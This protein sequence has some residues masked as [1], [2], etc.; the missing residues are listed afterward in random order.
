MYWRESWVGSWMPPSLQH[1]STC[2]V[3]DTHHKIAS[4]FYKR[5]FAGIIIRSS[6]SLSFKVLGDSLEPDAPP[7]ILLHGLLGKKTHWES[8]GKTIMNTAKRGV[9]VA[10]L[11][12]HGDSPHTSSHTY[13]DLAEDV[14]DL[15]KK[16]NID[17]TTLLGHSMGGRTAMS[18]ALMKPTVVSNLIVVDVSPVSSPGKMDDFF[19]RLWDVMKSVKFEAKTLA[20]AR[21]E[22]LHRLKESGV[23]E[24]FPTLNFLLMNVIERKNGQFGW[25]CNVVVLQK[26]FEYIASFPLELAGKFYQGPTLFIAGGESNYVP[27]SDTKGIREFFPQAEIQFVKKAGHNVHFDAPDTFLSLV[28]TF[29]REYS[30]K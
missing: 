18:L 27:L 8:V 21:Q 24:D 16:L 4:K 28:T 11:R 26:H 2:N 30:L 17:K 23:V 7:V 1:D 14:R 6:V 3:R 22:A 12:N 15:V 25:M 19:P 10:D 5:P 13:I 29:I 20:T 9:V